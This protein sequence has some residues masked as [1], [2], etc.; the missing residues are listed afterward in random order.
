MGGGMGFWG[1]RERGEYVT[2][3]QNEYRRYSRLDH[4]DTIKSKLTTDQ[5]KQ[6]KSWEAA[7]YIHV[8]ILLGEQFY[9]VTAGNK[10]TKTAKSDINV[11]YDV[12]S[13]FVDV[14]CYDL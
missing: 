13:I 6:I 1:E 7:D 8:G 4:V 2:G 11:A 9:H 14:P 5:K 10:I 12:Y 3:K